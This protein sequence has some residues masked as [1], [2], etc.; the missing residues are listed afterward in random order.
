MGSLLL[1]WEGLGEQ[2]EIQR[3]VCYTVVELHSKHTQE[4]EY[5][6]RQRSSEPETL[7]KDGRLVPKLHPQST[8][9]PLWPQTNKVTGV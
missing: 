7:S 4:L 2:V 9:W 6:G 8:R 1:T 5:S 3:G